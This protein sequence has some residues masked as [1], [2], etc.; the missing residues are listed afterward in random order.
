[1][2]SPKPQT[3]WHGEDI[4][5]ASLK[6]EGARNGAERDLQPFLNTTDLTGE[7]GDNNYVIT[8]G[9]SRVAV[10]IAKDS[11]TVKL[12]R[13]SRFIIDDYDTKEPMAYRLTKPLKLGF[14]YGSEGVYVFVMAECNLESDDNTELHI[15]NYYK[16][17]PRNC[18]SENCACDYTSTDTDEGAVWL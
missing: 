12:G 4:V 3:L 18:T 13:T 17:F 8:R 11:E 1:M 15:A 7:Y 14:S 2:G 9:D 6:N 10:T 5:C 16:H